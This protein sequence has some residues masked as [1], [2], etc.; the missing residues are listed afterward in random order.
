[1]RK[2]YLLTKTLSDFGVEATL[3]IKTPLIEFIYESKDGM[4][5]N[6]DTKLLEENQFR[7]HD[8]ID[9]FQGRVLACPSIHPISPL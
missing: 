6:F 1:M 4:L 3:L 2:I 9:L 8:V 7:L 5:G